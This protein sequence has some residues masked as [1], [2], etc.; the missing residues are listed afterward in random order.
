MVPLAHAN[1]GGGSTRLPAGWCGLVGLKPTR[2]RVPGRASISRLTAELG[3]T[4]IVRGTAVPPDE[5]LATYRQMRDFSKTAEPDGSAAPSPGAKL[6]FVVQEHHATALHWDFRLERDGVLV[7]W[8]LPK[9]VPP[10]PKQNHLAVQTEDHPLSYLDFAGEIP[11]KEYGGG[12]VI[13]WDR[14][15]YDL[16]KWWDDEVQVVLHGGRVQGKY[17]LFR[18]DGKNWMIHRMD[19]PQD[20]GREPM[21]TSIEPMLCKLAPLPKNDTEYAFEVKWDG[22]RAVAYVQGGRIRLQSRNMLDS[23]KQFP[24]LAALGE[25]LGAREV[26]LDGEIVAFTESGAPS[27]ELLQNR[28]G[29]TRPGDVRRRMQE[30]PAAFM[31]F[32]LLYLDGHSLMP[33]PYRERRRLLEALDLEG[34]SWKTPASHPGDGQAMYAASK[35]Q[36][37]EGV[38]A[39]RLDSPYEPGRRSGAW[40]K[41]KNTLRQ[42]FVIAGWTPGAGNREDSLGAV[43]VGYYDIS[44]DE[45]ARTGVPQRFHFAGKVGTGFDDRLFRTLIPAL[46]AR[47]VDRSPFDVGIPEPGAIFAAPELVCEV[48]FFEW[49]EAGTFRHPS[50]KG[51]RPDKDPRDVILETPATRSPVASEVV[52]RK[53]PG[54]RRAA[55]AV[56][57]STAAAPSRPLDAPGE[58]PEQPLARAAS[59]RSVPITVEG[60]EL[61]LSNLDKQLYA[62]GFTKAQVIDYYTR[63]APVALPHYRGRQ[64]TRKRYPDGPAGPFFFEKDAPSHTPA[65]V[66]KARV[67]SRHSSRD[68]SYILVDDLPTVVWL[69]NLAALELHP[70]LSLAE[71]MARPTCVVFDLD[72]GPPADLLDCA[73]VALALRELFDNLGLSGVAKTSGSKGMQVYLPLNTPTTYDETKQFALAVA[74]ILERQMPKRVVSSMSKAVRAGKVL[75]DW[76]QNDEHKTTI[77]VYSLRAREAPTVST[78]VSWEEIAAAVSE[79][80]ATLLSFQAPDVLQRVADS[81]DRFAPM[82]SLQQTLPSLSPA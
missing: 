35:A 44:R 60:R 65:W 58:A 53:G 49:T 72:P 66:H 42:E 46:T 31:I 28:L 56:A 38:V 3:V 62:T 32:D 55:R 16:V 20:P 57:E 4:R 10:D 77:G 11:D 74:K 59:S 67:Y 25:S 1:D 18:T 79:R 21:P 37:L 5:K 22:V 9:G 2:G 30:V 7:S 80:D 52:G 68:I 29:L 6:R 71:D 12:K 45:S 69:A 23:T 14:G 26:I 36:G 78:P 17:V 8:A 76:S 48:D 43:L 50:F 15:T 19:P 64:M 70:S 73:E 33:L 41:V 54:G 13:A 39:K 61:V 51:L 82:A 63:I 24:E 27:F 40:L 47:R 75:I 81:G 34:P